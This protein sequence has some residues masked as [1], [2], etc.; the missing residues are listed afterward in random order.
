MRLPKAVIGAVALA[1]LTGCGGYMASGPSMGGGNGY[2]VGSG[3]SGRG[4]GGGG[5]GGG[6]PVGS[7][8]VGFMGGIVFTSGHNGTANPAVDTI[9]VGGTVTWT[10]TSTGGVSHSVR[11][12][13]ATSFS[14]SAVMTGDG[15]SYAIKFAT[16]GTYQYN[17]AVHG[18]QMSGTV[19]VR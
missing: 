4:G 11:S 13:G 8:I 14:S 7:V 9:A 1:A 18:A 3:G 6:G 10:W 19:V 5:G 15:K 17:C 12:V 2:G 16:P